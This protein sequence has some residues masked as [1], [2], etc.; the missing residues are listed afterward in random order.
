LEQILNH[1][2]LNSEDIVKAEINI[3][4]SDGSIYEV[5]FEEVDEEVD[6]D[7]NQDEES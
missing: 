4:L 3:E 2:E 7:E 1:L 6:E 5:D